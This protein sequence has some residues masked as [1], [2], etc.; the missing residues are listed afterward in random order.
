MPETGRIDAKASPR[1]ITTI[2]DFLELNF[3]ESGRMKLDKSIKNEPTES[4]RS[5][6]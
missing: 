6:R 5:S 2:Q 4:A 1:L 3:R